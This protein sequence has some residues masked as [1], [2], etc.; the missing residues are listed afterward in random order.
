MLQENYFLEKSVSCFHSWVRKGWKCLPSHHF[1]MVFAEVKSKALS[2][3]VLFTI[4]SIS[5]SEFL[6]KCSSI[7]S[8][9]LMDKTFQREEFSMEILINWYWRGFRRCHFRWNVQCNAARLHGVE[10]VK[11]KWMRT[12]LEGWLYDAESGR[13]RQ[14]GFLSSTVWY[15]LVYCLRDVCNFWPSKKS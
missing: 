7:C 15:L 10:E 12:M 8:W 13:R 14:V 3:N 5:N 1:N 11:Y 6:W 4:N 9:R 2:K